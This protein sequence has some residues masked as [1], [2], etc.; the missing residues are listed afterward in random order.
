[1]TALISNAG[2]GI[3]Q[4]WSTSTNNF[5]QYLAVRIGINSE[6]SYGVIRVSMTS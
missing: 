5:Q 4:R 1:M 3:E 6:A 2:I